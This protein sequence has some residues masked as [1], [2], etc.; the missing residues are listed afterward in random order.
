MTLQRRPVGRGRWLAAGAAVVVAVGCV[1]PWYRAGGADGVPPLTVNGFEGAGILVFLAALAT[2]A[3]VSLPFAM[4]D[5]PIAVDR[6][7]AYGIIAAVAAAGLLIRVVDTLAVDGGLGIML[8]DRGPGTWVTAVGVI[9]LV[10]AT[11]E[12]FG[13]RRA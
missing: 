6:W 5:A 9:G 10:F 4:G 3:L 13:T 11:A 2:L 7:W 1:L 12:M 8:P